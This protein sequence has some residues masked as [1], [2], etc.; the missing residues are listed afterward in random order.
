MLLKRFNVIYLA[1]WLSLSVQAADL[2]SLV[3]A[4]RQP[5]AAWPS[6]ETDP[7]VEVAALAP[8]PHPNSLLMPDEFTAARI[9]LGLQLFFER[10]L[11]AS[12]QIACASCHD[13][14]MGWADGRRVSIG[15]NRQRGEMNAPSIVNSIF[16]HDIFWDGRAASLEEQV[17]ASWTNPIEMAGDLKESLEQIASIPGYTSLFEAAYGDADINTERIAGA[18]ATF[19]RSVNMTRTPFDRF[20][21]GDYDAL[22]DAQVR[23]LHLF[24]TKAR[25][26][27][28]HH[29]A[30]LSDQQYHHLGTSFERVGNFQ[31]RYRVTQQPEDMG[32]FRTPPLRGISATPPYMHNG[33]VTDLETLLAFY[34]I[35]WWQNAPLPDKDP[36]LPLAQLSPLIKPLALSPEE[37][38]DLKAFLNSLTGLM[39]YMRAPEELPREAPSEL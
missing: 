12:H 35:G 5:Q 18:I 26:M 34:N 11:S 14:D 36:E 10:R 22:N 30:L 3:A 9:R 38:D 2:E 17:I 28:C 29:G 39:P 8:L 7:G 27:N 1:T 19:M 24:R 6:A 16:L 21:E 15:H 13:P 37:L 23:G 31:G 25:C 20:L 4:Y 32:A 33:F